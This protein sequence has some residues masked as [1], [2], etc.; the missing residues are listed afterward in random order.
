[1]GE[2]A[3]NILS[4]VLLELEEDDAEEPTH[5]AGY[6]DNAVDDESA[7]SAPVASRTYATASAETYAEPFGMQVHHSGF[8]S[9]RLATAFFT[10]ALVPP[11]RQ[12]AGVLHRVNDQGV[13]LTCK[14]HKACVG[15]LC[16]RGRTH[17]ETQHD[18]WQWLSR[19]LPGTESMNEQPHLQAAQSL[20]KS[21]G[22]RV[23]KSQT[24]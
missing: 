7:P 8:L 17:Q 21:Y 5:I 1:M 12:E 23:R 15:W 11:K 9:G 18:L 22:M 13:K 2:E 14:F 19:A 20:K 16:D 10:G 24:C 4:G 3:L 6:A